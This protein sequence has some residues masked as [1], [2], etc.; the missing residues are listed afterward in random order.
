M[1]DLKSAYDTVQRRHIRER[2]RNSLH[3]PTDMSN[4]PV[5]FAEYVLL[6]AKALQGLQSLMDIGTQ[7][8]PQRVMTWNNKMGNSQVLESREKKHKRFKLAG[9]ILQQVP[10]VRYLGVS[11]SERRMNDSKLLYRIRGAKAISNVPSVATLPG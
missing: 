4:I 10:E 2:R 5:L 7:W 1:V 3:P 9:K 11:L 6:T 8:A